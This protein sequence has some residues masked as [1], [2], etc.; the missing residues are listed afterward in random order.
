MKKKRDRAS[1]VWSHLSKFPL[2][3]RLLIFIIF[4]SVIS[5]SA[6]NSYSQETKFNLVF[7]QMS[8]R[9][10]LRA[11]ENN[12]EFIFLYSEKAV[13]L[14]RKVSLKVRN[15]SVSE[16]LDEV[17]KG[18]DNYYEIHDRQIAIL[19]RDSPKA[20]VLF[21]KAQIAQTKSATGVVKD[22]RGVPLPGVTVVIKG[23]T[24]G[25]V[26]DV[27]GNFSLSGIQ[28]RDI[29]VFTFVGMTSQEIPVAGKDHLQVTL[30][31]TTAD[32]A[33]VTVVAYGVQKKVSITAAVSSVEAKELKVTSSA[34]VAN[35]LA[36]RVAGLTSIQRGGG[37]PGVDDASLYLR[38]LA[39]INGSSPLILIDGVPR[40]NIRT[41]DVNEI[42]SVSVLKDASSTA[43]FGVRGANGV[44][45][46]T[47]KRGKEGKPELSVNVTQSFSKLTREPDMPGSVE[48][49]HLR[50]EALLNDGFDE[51][52]F[53]DDVIAKFE[54]PLEGL[55]PNDPDYEQQAAVRRYMYPSNNW[56]K[57]MTKQWSPQT[58]ANVN[59]S[60]GTDKISYFLN[61]GYFHQGGNFETEKESILHY[62]PSFWLDRYSFRSNVDYKV[63]KLLTAFLNLGTYIE[64]V[65]MPNPGVMYGGDR[66]WLV[67]D[68]I[69]QAQTILPMSP[70]PGTIAGF[71]VPANRPLDPTYLQ[72][73]HYA[74]R[75]P[76]LIMNWFGYD[77]QTR[78]NL[79]SSFGLNFDLSAITKG[80]SAKGMIS[81]DSRGNNLDRGNYFPSVYQ[82]N[83]DPKTNTLTFS[84][85]ETRADNFTMSYGAGSAYNITYEGQVNYSNTFGKHT[86][87]GMVRGSRD[88]W[89]DGGANIVFNV[90]GFAGR[91][92]YDY[93]SRYFA[94][95]NFGY[96]GSEQFSPEK[97]F[98]FFPSGAVGWALSNE[99]FLKDDPVVTFLKLR[100]SYGKVGN[101]KMGTSR[102]LYQDNITM[103][104]GFSGS[105]GQGAGVNEGL[106]GNKMLTWEIA[107]KY[108]F[109]ID[110]TLFKD[111]KGQIDIFKEDRSQILL[112]RASIPTWQGMPLGNIPK[113]NMGEVENKGFEVE[114]SY[115]KKVNA[116]LML[117]FKGQFSYNRNK[118]LN[119]D[120][121]PRDETYAYKYRSTGYPIGQSF[122]YLID[123]NQDGG[124]WTEEK[125]ASIYGSGEGKIRYDFGTPV[126]GDFVYKDLN[127][128][129]LVND[130][131]Q[132]P[133]GYGPYPRISYGFSVSGEW[134][135][136]DAYVFF[137]G[138]G[139]FNRTSLVEQGVSEYIIRGT[140]FPYHK[141]AWTQERWENQEKITY[142][143]LHTQAGVNHKANSFFIMDRDF[144]R[145]KNFEIGYTLPEN[146]LK[147]VGVSSMRVFVN[148]QNV[149]TW[150]PKFRANHLDPENDDSIGYPQTT[151]FS[152]GTNIKF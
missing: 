146:S 31:E 26:T 145:L 118:Q 69:Y 144:I 64:K 105:L 80:L 129:G 71:G 78:A 143:K 93:D 113:V 132:A 60:G 42:E 107:E 77:L 11:V 152:F 133:I 40:D 48:Y 12:S 37:Q 122:G 82:A 67:R 55:D 109:G 53:T 51:A 39:T 87:G 66:N 108:N 7:E 111:I 17:F 76:Y 56:Y 79:N 127:N 73:G 18:T 116:E 84:N 75:S 136:F 22:E 86:V 2:K 119:M 139:Q 45:V 8:V 49:M 81:Y 27:D 125:L 98:G 19:S 121:V 74:D 131:D 134:K 100:L 151:V 1:L 13:D 103:G 83:V 59:L 47:T 72:A 88:Y 141:T 142:P 43:V 35:A 16:I 58:I 95:A 147:K 90:V 29:L 130:K 115:D 68:M 124:Y 106:L 44:L 96:N 89:D 57:M 50:N 140:Y 117:H 104:S 25:T 65:N 34:S 70:G 46:I 28:E 101:D 36:G 120:E 32:I 135:G 4:F 112:T 97:R 99:G 137:Q 150:S 21:V 24:R 33:E 148:G 138:L 63:S 91:A 126:S 94:E 23:T 41:L 61:A 15:G 114:L 5:A 10:V 102:F 20:E 128:D 3:M 30:V 92:T 54:N 6:D 123:F 62:D 52:I 38:G 149:L 14:D 9:Q 85:Y 110:F